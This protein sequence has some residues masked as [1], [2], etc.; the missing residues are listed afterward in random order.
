MVLEDTPDSLSLMSAQADNS[1]LRRSIGAVELEAEPPGEDN[2]EK[3]QGF[4]DILARQEALLQLIC[5]KLPSLQVA[6]EELELLQSIERQIL[7]ESSKT[8]F[9]WN[10]FLQLTGILFVILFGAFAVLSYIIGKGTDTKS[11]EA[12]QLAFL[13]LCL[14]SNSVSKIHLDS[15]SIQPP[16]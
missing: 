11:L 15:P 8:Q 13:A 10:V 1:Q 5:D 3:I 7:S 4:S 12:N 2:K 6:H 16:I 9:L 14:S